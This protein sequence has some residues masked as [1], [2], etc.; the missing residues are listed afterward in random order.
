MY[1]LWLELSVDVLVMGLLMRELPPLSCCLPA[2]QPLPF[3]NCSVI[4]DIRAVSTSLR[5]LS[6]SPTETQAKLRGGLIS[7]WLYKEN[8]K[9]RDWKNVFTLHI[10]PW[11]L[12][13]YDFVNPFKKNS[14]GC[15]E[16]SKSQRLIST[17]TY[18]FLTFQSVAMKYKTVEWNSFFPKLCVVAT[19]SP[20]RTSP[21]V[22]IRYWKLSGVEEEV[23]KPWRKNLK[24]S[25]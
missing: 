19:G 22:N 11:A 14:F 7:L 6:F 10:P 17:P 9:L 21:S 15:A 3:H 24:R 18:T 5:L 16:N 25:S 8:N 20:F 23:L 13:T 1:R 4:A 12:H 2:F